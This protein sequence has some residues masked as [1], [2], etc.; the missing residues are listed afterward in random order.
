[1]IGYILCAI[2]GMLAGFTV[3]ALCMG[4]KDDLDDGVKGEIKEDNAPIFTNMNGKK[5][6]FTGKAD[7]CWVFKPIEKEDK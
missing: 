7:D 6:E 4:S 2:V 1:M 5:F 3:A